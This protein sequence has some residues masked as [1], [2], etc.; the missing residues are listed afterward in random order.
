MSRY[1]T[2]TLYGEDLETVYRGGS[3]VRSLMIEVVM[4][5]MQKTYAE[6]K[7]LLDTKVRFHSWSHKSGTSLVR[8]GKK[9]R[10]A[11]PHWMSELKALAATAFYT[12]FNKL[13]QENEVGSVS[14][15]NKGNMSVRLFPVTCL[16]CLWDDNFVKT[17]KGRLSMLAALEAVYDK[18][19]KLGD[20]VVPISATNRETAYKVTALL[21]S[22][23]VLK[24]S[25]SGYYFLYREAHVSQ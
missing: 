4:S 17:V 16:R 19:G 1:R 6:A 14:Y 10:A 22:L 11:I 24:V 18:W 5:L 21:Y 15:D 3:R 8:P 9:L 7:V 23:L 12:K 20:F 13:H 2:D 25:A